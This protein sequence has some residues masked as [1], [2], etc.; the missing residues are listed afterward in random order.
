MKYLRPFLSH[1]GIRHSHT[2]ILS[3]VFPGQLL[4]V[5][6]GFEKFSGSEKPKPS[7]KDE[8]GDSGKKGKKEPSRPYVDS[9]T[10][11][12]IL[13]TIALAAYSAY[14][15]MDGNNIAYTSFINDLLVNGHVESLEIVNRQYVRVKVS[16]Q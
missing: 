4:S 11:N 13:G 16:L 5:P 3:Q 8:G 1:K 15:N 12:L 7:G 6:R 2:P 10:R 9:M 14:S